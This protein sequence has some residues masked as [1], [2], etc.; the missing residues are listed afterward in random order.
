MNEIL[1]DKHENEP[2]SQNFRDRF[3]LLLVV[4]IAFIALIGI[5]QRAQ[6]SD[7]EGPAISEVA[8]QGD[9]AM[10]LFYAYERWMSLTPANTKNLQEAQKRSAVTWYERAVQKDPSPAN[11]RR[12]IIAQHPSERQKAIR[13]METK[14]MQEAA[15]WREIYI[16]NANLSPKQVEKYSAKI[17]SIKLG[18]YEHLA[19]ADLYNRAGRAADA[20]KQHTEA[21]RTASRT[22]GWLVGLL[23]T[24]GMLGLVGVALIIW[25]ATTGRMRPVSALAEPRL[26][27][28]RFTSAYLLEIFLVYLVFWIVTQV[29]VALVVVWISPEVGISPFV[30]IISTAGAY[31]LGGVLATGYL[32]WRLNRTGWTLEKIGLSTK[33][34]VKDIIWGIGGYAA[35]LPLVIIAGLLSQVIGKYI[36]T[37]PNPV[38][39]LFMESETLFTRLILLGLVAVAAPFFEELFFR[40]VL[41]ESFRARWGVNAGI[42]LSALAFALVHPLPLGLLP[43]FALGSVF[44]VLAYQRGSLLPAMVAHGINNTVAFVMLLILME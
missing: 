44:A 22:M 29:A 18:W 3:V 27:G 2:S 28:K 14:Q 25:Y 35:A 26:E 31:I 39:P 43:I 6:V 16:S 5:A 21:V 15:I 34:P 8:L 1:D 32:L 33:N 7:T 9:I 12:L 24:L 11:I 4:L 10:K 42:I 20:Q 37:P 23:L 30:A 36:P 40:G 41:F 17:R 19:L 13:L 38:I